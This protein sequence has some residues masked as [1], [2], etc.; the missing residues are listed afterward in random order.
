[1][2]LIYRNLKANEYMSIKKLGG[3]AEGRGLQSD[4]DS[5]IGA[6]AVSEISVSSRNCF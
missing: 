4:R 2:N 3:E 5:I 1:M 6:G